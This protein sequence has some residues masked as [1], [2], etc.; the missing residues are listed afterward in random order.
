MEPYVRPVQYYETDMMGVAHHANYL[1]WMEEAR[2]D[3]MDR[4]GFPYTRMEAGG[5]VSPVVEIACRY[6][7]SCTFGDVIS[8]AVEVESFSPAKMTLTYEM[9]DQKGDLV[10]T[11]R[12]EHTLLD[13]EG[14][15]VRIRRV[16]PEFCEAI[17]KLMEEKPF[18]NN[19]DF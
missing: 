8:I 2:I 12:S 4:I 3:F 6:R 5:V 14:R 10:S 7:K 9:R 16:M 15:I 17:E 18:P 19:N 11:A 1:H 13:R